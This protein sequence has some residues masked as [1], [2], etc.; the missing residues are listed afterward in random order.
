MRNLF[1][2]FAMCVALVT[3]QACGGDSSSTEM[4]NTDIVPSGTYTGTAERVDTEEQEIYVETQDGK[5]LELYFTDQTKL[6]QNGET[7]SFDALQKGQ[8]VEVEVE[9]KGQRLEPVAVRILE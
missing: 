4:E 6:T 8:N 2:T 7:V 9:K 3:L 1:F 5:T